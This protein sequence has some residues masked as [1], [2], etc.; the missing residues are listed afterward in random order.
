VNA[1]ALFTRRQSSSAPSAISCHTISTPAHIRPGRS[2]RLG[3]PG[4]RRRR[5]PNPCRPWIA[6]GS[7]VARHDCWPCVVLVRM[8]EMQWPTIV[9]NPCFAHE[10]MYVEIAEPV[11]A[12]C[13]INQCR[14]VSPSSPSRTRVSGRCTLSK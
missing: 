4:P 9:Q 5:E 13:S 8:T 7:D 10:A 11:L 12:A 14:L 6:H 1:Q 3:A 2:P